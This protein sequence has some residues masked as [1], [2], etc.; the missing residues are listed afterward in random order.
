MVSRLHLWAAA[1]ERL[2]VGDRHVSRARAPRAAGKITPARGKLDAANAAIPAVRWPSLVHARRVAR[3]LLGERPCLWPN[4]DRPAFDGHLAVPARDGVAAAQ[5]SLDVTATGTGDVRSVAITGEPRTRLVPRA[6][7]RLPRPPANPPYPGTLVLFQGFGSVDADGRSLHFIWFYCDAGRL[8]RVYYETTSTAGNYSPVTGTCAETATFI[9]P[10]THLDALDVEVPRL[11][12]GFSITSQDGSITL[13]GSGPGTMLDD[14]GAPRTALVFNELDCRDGRD[15]PGTG[16]ELVRAPRPAVGSEQASA[17]L[18]AALPLH[19]GTKNLGIDSRPRLRLQHLTSGT[20]V[21]DHVRLH[22][23]RAMIKVGPTKLPRL[24]RTVV[25]VALVSFLA[26]CRASTSAAPDGRADGVAV[27]AASSR[28]AG[29]DGVAVEASR[30]TRVD[31]AATTCPSETAGTCAMRRPARR[32]AQPPRAPARPMARAASTATIRAAPR[33]GR[34]RSAATAS[35]RR[36]GRPIRSCAALTPA[37]DCPRRR[38]RPAGMRRR[39]FVVPAPVRGYGVRMHDLHMEWCWQP[40][41]TVPCGDAALAVRRTPR[42]CR[43]A[44]PGNH[45]N[46][47]DD[48]HEPRLV[49]LPVRPGRDQKLPRRGLDRNQRRPMPGVTAAASW[50]MHVPAS[51]RCALALV[52]LVIGCRDRLREQLGRR[53]RHVSLFNETGPRA[54]RRAS[55]S[56]IW[57]GLT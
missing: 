57:R 33:A 22:L 18:R 3:G 27:E 31:G 1:D 26:A 10:P 36:S 20:H 49:P 2:P 5:F 28:E 52:I 14:L 23:E 7:R 46:A 45:A 15:A 53:V 38:R 37:T 42:R 41:R 13:D 19:V 40:D 34:P 4:C 51:E 16:L 25:A 17:R 21:P 32:R 35:G 29:A 54:I 24:A 55:S 12:C 44:L 50:L 48:V 8:D 30:E 11:S 43:R 47:W 6:E 56:V 9:Q 39:A